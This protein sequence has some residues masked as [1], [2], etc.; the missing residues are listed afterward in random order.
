M[1]DL[2]D[3]VDVRERTIEMRACF[4]FLQCGELLEVFRVELGDLDIVGVLEDG[5]IDMCL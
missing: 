2:S 5:R 3:V 4:L 1:F